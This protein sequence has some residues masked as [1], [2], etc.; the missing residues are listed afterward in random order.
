MK[1]LTVYRLQTAVYVMIIL[2]GI[3]HFLFADFNFSLSFYE[4]VVTGFLAASVLVTLYSLV[5]LIV[6]GIITLN[7]KAMVKAELKSL[8]INLM[9]YYMVIGVSLYLLT[10]VR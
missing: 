4:S 5:A 9:L 8:F 1:I 2:F 3:Q 6:E 7:R 10:Q